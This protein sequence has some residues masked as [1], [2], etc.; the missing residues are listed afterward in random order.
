MILLAFFGTLSASIDLSA[1]CVGLV[2]FGFVVLGLCMQFFICA[3]VELTLDVV[4]LGL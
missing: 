1:S 2:L 3:A 4:V